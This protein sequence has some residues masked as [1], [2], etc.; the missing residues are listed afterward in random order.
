LIFIRRRAPATSS[1]FSLARNENPPSSLRVSLTE[2]PNKRL[3]AARRKDERYHRTHYEQSG[4]VSGLLEYGLFPSAWK[5]S[6]FRQVVRTKTI[7]FLQ[8]CNSREISLGKIAKWLNE[9]G[10]SPSRGKAWHKSTVRFLLGQSPESGEETNIRTLVRLLKGLHS[11]E[12]NQ[13]PGLDRVIESSESTE[14]CARRVWDMH[15][16]F[17]PAFRALS[18]YL[19]QAH[20]EHES[21]A[22]RGKG[23]EMHRR[24]EF[25]FR[26]LGTPALKARTLRDIL[27]QAK[28]SSKETLAWVVELE[29]LEKSKTLPDFLDFEPSKFDMEL[30]GQHKTHEA[31][32]R[33]LCKLEGISTRTARRY[34]PHTVQ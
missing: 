14:E 5:S 13:Q 11:A 28:S 12:Q 18:A 2:M 32:L 15:N 20:R 6:W 34:R 8:W 23:T 19:V 24:G 9:H 21:L 27:Q 3:T 30:L 7:A 4:D 1:I 10:P 22:E 16:L 26:F 31:L 33:I 25:A 29:H 17:L